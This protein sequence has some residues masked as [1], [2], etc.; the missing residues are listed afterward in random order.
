MRKHEVVS[1]EDLENYYKKVRKFKFESFVP[2]DI[3]ELIERFFS[4]KEDTYFLNGKQQGY[5][6]TNRSIDDFL[7]IAKYYFP[8]NSIKEFREELKSF[9]KGNGLEEGIYRHPYTM[10]CHHIRKQVIWMAIYKI[11]NSLE[12]ITFKDSGFRNCN[13]KIF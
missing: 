11:T 9:L 7:I 12:H 6:G 8:E 13:L 2:S 3:K 10:R 1:E 5:Y 4:K